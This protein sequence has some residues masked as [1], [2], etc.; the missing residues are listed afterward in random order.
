MNCTYKKRKAQQL[1]EFAIVLPILMVILLL[2]IETGFAVYTKTCLSEAV[3]MSLFQ[4]NTLYKFWGDEDQKKNNISIQIENNIKDYFTNH[5]IP[6]SG[7]IKA[8]IEKIPGSTTSLLKVTYDYYPIFRLPNIF[9][10]EIIPEKFTFS[11]AQVIN[12]TLI[13]PSVFES[14]FSTT[15]LSSIGKYNATADPRSSILKNRVVQ[16]TGQPTNLDTRKTTAFLVGFDTA[17]GGANLKY[18]R[19]FDWWGSDLLPPN[20]A[21]NIQTGHITVKSPYY[22]GANW[23]DTNVPYNWVLS[24]LGFAHAVYTKADTNPGFVDYKLDLANANAAMNLGLPWC[25]QGCNNCG[26]DVSDWSDHYTD[27]LLKR[28]ISTLYSVSNPPVGNLDPLKNNGASA[29]YQ[30]TKTYLATSSD[31]DLTL[32]IPNDSGAAAA[33]SVFQFKFKIDANGKLSAAGTDTDIVDAYLDN[34]YDNIPNAWDKHPEY[35][36]ANGN[37]TIDGLENANIVYNNTFPDTM[38][39][40]ANYNYSLKTIYTPFKLSDGSLEPTLNTAF[41]NNMR[42]FTPMYDYVYAT[43]PGVNALYFYS[44]DYDLVRK[45]PTWGVNA[46]NPIVQKSNFIY[47]NVSGTDIVLKKSYEKDYLNTGPFSSDKKVKN[48]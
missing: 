29:S 39:I 13:E 48:E 27:N 35:F 5:N 23:L 14:G 15:N 38:V 7:S 16:Y 42:T 19:L 45:M 4:V 22:N 9:N 44:K 11:S 8:S 2:I 43:Q 6:Y 47:G 1:V 36:D 20:M 21:F 31:Y 46:G 41:T 37:G 33:H 24:A 10:N 32:T 28:G 12:N 26:T 40:A 18:A 30:G 34:D 17:A 25:N 3:K